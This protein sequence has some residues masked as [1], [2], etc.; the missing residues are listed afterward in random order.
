MDTLKNWWKNF[1]EKHETASQ[2]IVFFI[3]SNGV[4]VLQLVLMPVFKWI[5]SFTSLQ[6][7]LS[8]DG[9]HSLFERQ[10]ARGDNFR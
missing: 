2:F 5:F 10:E 3:L 6:G 1:A 7:T 4:T 9:G 8:R